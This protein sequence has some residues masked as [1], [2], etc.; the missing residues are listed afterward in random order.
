MSR[1]EMPENYTSLA[2]L[3][4]GIEIAPLDM[5]ILE[6]RAAHMSAGEIGRLLGL[7]ARQVT[8]REENM[9]RRARRREFAESFPDAMLVVEPAPEFRTVP[10]LPAST[11]DHDRCIWHLI[12]LKRADHSPA[13][14]EYK[15]PPGDNFRIFVPPVA[16]VSGCGSPAALCAAERGCGT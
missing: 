14:T 9:V 3:D 11:T 12:D 2:V 16:A 7:T 15:I 6:A 5:S 1:R 10:D 8:R 13:R 4:A